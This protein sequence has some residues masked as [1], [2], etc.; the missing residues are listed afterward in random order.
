MEQAELQKLVE[1]IS[2]ESFQ[3]PFR[4]KAFFNNRLRTTGG[5]YMLRDH[6][7]E[8]NKKYLEQFGVE[9]LIGIIKHEL[10]HYHLHLEGKGY[11]HR[12][13]DFRA[14]MKKV[15]APRFCSTLPVH[16]SKSRKQVLYRCQNCGHLYER[17]RKI[18]TRKYVCGKCKGK[19]G[20]VKETTLIEQ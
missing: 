10:C 18:D 11:K 13:Q 12:D 15:G 16:T 20:F 9:E 17:R 1:T 5:R 6:R 14:L 2:L 19:L 8:L 4:H 3:K 7:I